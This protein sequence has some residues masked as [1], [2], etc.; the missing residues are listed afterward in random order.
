M[1]PSA[2]RQKISKK[3][4]IEPALVRAIQ[5]LSFNKAQ[6]ESILHRT[7]QQPGFY[8]LAPRLLS[9]QS[10]VANGIPRQITSR[11]P[12]LCRC[13]HQGSK[14]WSFAARDHRSRLSLRIPMRTPRRSC[15]LPTGPWSG[16]LSI[17]AIVWA[18]QVGAFGWSS[19]IAGLNMSTHSSHCSWKL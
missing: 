3:R 1:T 10:P 11:C 8:A 17:S 4:V 5:D 12:T 2:R 16:I 9:L 19:F 18:S 15:P 6:D 14:P 13:P 7:S